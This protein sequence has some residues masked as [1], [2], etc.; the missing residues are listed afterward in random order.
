[1]S[2]P[3]RPTNCGG[4]KGSINNI[5]DELTKAYCDPHY[6]I[7]KDFDNILDDIARKCSKY[8]YYSP[9]QVAN[10]VIN[11]LKQHCGAEFALFVAQE[12]IKRL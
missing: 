5:T 8:S 7:S 3:I 6:A 12:L 10:N 2:F 4:Q 9:N 1:M 11:N